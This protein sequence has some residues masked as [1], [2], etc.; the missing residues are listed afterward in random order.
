MKEINIADI[1][2]FHFGQTENDSG[3]SGCTVIINEN[4]AVAGVDVRGGSPG[5]RETDVLRSENLVSSI[6]GVFLS[7]GSAFGLDVGSGV[8]KFLKERG[9]G[10]DVEV[11]NVPIVPGAILFD[12]TGDNSEELPDAEMGYIASRAA[13]SP[14]SIKQGNY[15]AGAGAIVGKICGRSHSMKGGV[16]SYA[17]QVGDIQIGAVVAVNSFGDVIDPS[18]GEILAGVQRN[19]M[20]LKSENVL[21]DQI[22]ED[23]TDRFKGNTTIGTI[24]TNARVSKPQA[25]KLAGIAHDGL[26][27]T[28]RPSHTFV[29]GDTLFF[30]SNGDVICDLNGLGALAVQ[31]VEKAILNAVNHAVSTEGVLA[32]ADIHRKG[33]Y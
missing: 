21:M 12:L 16:G 29:D 27:R 19:G 11:A 9:I 14:S 30:L 4:G 25:N 22:G 15:G 33:K 28:I 6:H 20:F 17:C 3:N 31:V 18:T 26:A 13:M 5:T 32:A 7:G 23:L 10:F 2:G 1:K 8:M 24:V